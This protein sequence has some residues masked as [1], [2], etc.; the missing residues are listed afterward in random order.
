MPGTRLNSNRKKIEKLMTSSR[1]NRKK[2]LIYAFTEHG[3]SCNRKNLITKLYISGC[4]HIKW[5]THGLWFETYWT[6]TTYNDAK[7]VAIYI[8]TRKFLYDYC[9]LSE[10]L[11]NVP[12]TI[13]MVNAELAVFVVNSEFDVAASIALCKYWIRKSGL[14]E[15][16]WKNEWREKFTFTSDRL[17]YLKPIDDSMWPV[18]WPWVTDEKNKNV[19]YFRT[20]VGPEI[21]LSPP[22]KFFPKGGYVYSLSNDHY[23]TF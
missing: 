3:L 22:C 20:F 12:R 6:N 10:E 4:S 9:N 19:E 17:T 15:D 23:R 5:R 18:E 21:D 7:D 1:N 11:K 16:S 13:K 14:P 8:A 2:D